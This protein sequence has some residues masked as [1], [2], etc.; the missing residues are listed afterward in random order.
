MTSKE[1]NTPAEYPIRINKYL[2]LQKICSRKEADDFVSAGKVTIN[3]RVAVL[4]DKVE[5]SDK[6]LV[7]G[8]NKKLIYLAFH[9]PKGVMTHSPQFGEKEVRDMVQV[10]QDVF[11][12]GRLDK[13]S[14]GLMI[15]TNDGRL[16][17]RLLNPL[18]NHQKEYWVKTSGSINEY[19]LHKLSAGV[20]L[21]D[22]YVTKPCITKKVANNR[23]SIILTEGK[24]HQIRRMCAALGQQIVSLDRVRIM[25]IRLG[26]LA[27]GD[28]REIIGSELSRFLKSVEL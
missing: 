6:V 28:Y 23:F 25:N 16:T 4:G 7:T 21:E 10:E 12:L 8:N 3:G 1:N 19:F 26:K 20:T 5:K 24:K 17:D 11:P 18:Y 9:K 22:G 15:L 13:D 2:A 27:A 14:S